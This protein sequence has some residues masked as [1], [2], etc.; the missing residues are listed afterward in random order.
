MTWQL[1]LTSDDV[2]P[3]YNAPP[4]VCHSSVNHILVNIGPVTVDLIP[5][6]V[7]TVTTRGTLSSYSL[8]VTYYASTSSVLGNKGVDKPRRQYVR[9]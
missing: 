1:S 6:V 3:V 7:P 9:V 5:N 8:A 4:F 2:S